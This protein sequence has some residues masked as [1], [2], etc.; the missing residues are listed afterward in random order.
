[1]PLI[2]E[3][4]ADEARRQLVARLPPTVA[5]LE[6]FEIIDNPLCEESDG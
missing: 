2:A 4:A 3:I 6:P 1:M 5:P